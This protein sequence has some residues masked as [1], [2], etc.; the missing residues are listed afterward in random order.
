MISHK[1]VSTVSITQMVPAGFLSDQFGVV[2]WVLKVHCHAQMGDVLVKYYFHLLGIETIHGNNWYLE[3]WYVMTWEWDSR[4][5]SRIA[6]T[7]FNTSSDCALR[8]WLERFK[9]VVLVVILLVKA[10]Y[11]LDSRNHG[12]VCPQNSSE[13]LCQFCCITQLLWFLFKY[14]FIVCLLVTLTWG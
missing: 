1:N 11:L 5:F 14:S 2:P 4:A 10:Q 6:S 8:V 7:T 13:S 9:Y 3:H 12:S